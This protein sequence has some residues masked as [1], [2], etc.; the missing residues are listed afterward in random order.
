MTTRI[1]IGDVREKLKELEANSCDACVTS[2]PY[3]NLRSYLPKGHPDK[4]K[5][6]GQEKSIEAYVENLVT[7]FREVRRVL[8]PDGTLW[9]N[10]GDCHAGGG[11]GAR[12]PERWPKQ[13]RNDH[14]TQHAKRGTGFR[15]K[16]LLG[17]PW[18]VAFALQAD[19]WYLRKFLPWVKRNPMP[20]SVKDRPIS[21]VET[22]FMLTKTESNYYDHAA[23]RRRMQATSITRIAQDIEKQKGST[24]ANG[25]TRPGKVV[26][27]MKQ[28]GHSRKHASFNERYFDPTKPKDEARAFRDNDLFFDSLETPYGAI[29]DADGEIIALDV[30]TTGFKG[31]HFAT[32]PTNLIEPLFIASCRPH[33]TVLDPFA[34]A[35]TTGL[36]A[37]RL[38]RNSILI[39]L[40]PA[41]VQMIQD[42]I[43][44]EATLLTEIRA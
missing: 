29:Y 34:G 38:S 21:S 8:K 27:A 6:L 4:G 20:E 17:V 28:D 44:P 18:K 12:D 10:L 22:V 14:K 33:G 15:N 41:A 23:I 37:D 5:E 26:K 13:S 11:S 42:R 31:A 40:N 1:L 43:T 36:V 35:G 19:G 30:A 25:G 24:R 3:Y 16:E 2:P 7:V 9:L 32:F 39:E